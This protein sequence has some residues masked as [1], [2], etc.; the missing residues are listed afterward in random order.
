MNKDSLTQIGEYTYELG[1]DRQNKEKIYKDSDGNFFLELTNGVIITYPF[2][3]RIRDFITTW[4][5]AYYLDTVD[6]KHHYVVYSDEVTFDIW[7]NTVTGLL[8]LIRQFVIPSNE[9]NKAIESSSEYNQYFDDMANAGF[10]KEKK[11]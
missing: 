1:L 4:D 2:A 8:E 10:G 7:G 9:I 11:E 3:I 5:N 6:G